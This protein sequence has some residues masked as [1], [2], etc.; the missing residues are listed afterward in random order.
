MIEAREGSETEGG[1]EMQRWAGWARPVPS[2]E[3]RACRSSEHVD[4]ED[5]PVMVFNGMPAR[6]Q[7]SN[8]LNFQIELLIILGK[9]SK[10]IFL[11]SRYS[12]LLEG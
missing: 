4:F 11:R 6:I 10:T 1:G 5:T 12:V 9:E 8:F 3:S 2:Q 7:N